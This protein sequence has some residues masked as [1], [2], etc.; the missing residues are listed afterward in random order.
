MG[1]IQLRL[2]QRDLALQQFRQLDSTSDATLKYLGRLFSGW[3]L[4][5]E[6]RV[7]DAVAAYRAALEVVPRARAAT[8]LLTFVLVMNHRLAEAE[9]VAGA[10]LSASEVPDDP[11]R[12]YPLGD[13][14]AYLGLIDRLREAIR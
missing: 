3:T 9:A 5:R 6:S 8:T 1:Y 4:A 11:W 7:D 2:G 14:R 12:D 13:Y 10:R